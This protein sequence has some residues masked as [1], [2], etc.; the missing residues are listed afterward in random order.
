MALF[1]V[2]V[3]ISPNLKLNLRKKI[4][5]EPNNIE[6]DIARKAVVSFDSPVLFQSLSGMVILLFI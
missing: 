2:S 4:I 5:G 1:A 3:V 6:I